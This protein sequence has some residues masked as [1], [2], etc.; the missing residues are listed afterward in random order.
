MQ[1]AGQFAVFL[2][3]FFQCILGIR[4]DFD[5]AGN[6][7]RPDNRYCHRRDRDDQS[8]QDSQSQVRIQGTCHRDGARRRGNQAVC[9]VQAAGESGRHHSQRDVGLL[10]QRAADR[11]Q[12]HESGITEYGDTGDIAHRTHCKDAVLFA[13]DVQNRVCHGERCAGFLQDGT[14]DCAA[15]D[16]NTD[17]CHDASEAAFDLIDNLGGRNLGFRE[18]RPPDQANCKRNHQ[19]DDKRMHFQF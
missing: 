18:D 1:R 2:L 3:Q 19:H 7:F 5:L 11:G 6:H 16:N 8:D 4:R 12:N 14:D 17:T 13:D 9:G 15:K 10:C